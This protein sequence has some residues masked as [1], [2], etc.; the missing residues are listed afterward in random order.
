MS[1]FN[2]KMSEKPDRQEKVVE[3]NGISAQ[4]KT[5]YSRRSTLFFNGKI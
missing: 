1:S 2:I 3:K 5:A 4:K